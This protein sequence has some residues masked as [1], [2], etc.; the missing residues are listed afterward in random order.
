MLLDVIMRVV[1]LRS[2][3]TSVSDLVH[4]ASD[5]AA[6]IVA[7]IPFHL[8]ADVEEYVQ[9]ANA[10]TQPSN[11]KVKPVGGLLLLHPLYATAR[12]SIVSTATRKYLARCLDWIGRCMG[13]GQARLLA[14]SVCARMDGDMPSTALSPHLPFQ[15]MSE[16]HVL[17]WAG[18][19][20]QPT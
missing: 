12:C 6:A 15:E 16:G 19:L 8:T 17:I 5:L 11:A 10:G 14:T 7:S 9:R 4:R 20:L 1:L 3:H 18:M 13:I 2:E